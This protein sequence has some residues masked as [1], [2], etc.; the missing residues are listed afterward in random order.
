MIMW[1]QE[2]SKFHYK[3]WEVAIND[4][5]QKAAEKHMKEYLNYQ[6]MAETAAKMIGEDV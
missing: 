6:E 4:N 3:Q 5:K 2:K 1:Y